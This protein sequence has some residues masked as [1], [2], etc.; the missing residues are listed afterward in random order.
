MAENGMEMEIIAYRDCKHC[1]IRFENG[2]IVKNK[3]YHNFLIGHVG[4]PTDN[5]IGQKSNNKNGMEMTII[6]YRSAKD[7]DVRFEN[8]IIVKHR[9]YNNFIKGTIELPKILR[10]HEKHIANNGMEME[11]IAYRSAT[12]MDIRFENGKIQRHVSYANFKRGVVGRQDEPISSRIG[13]IRNANNGLEMRLLKV[14]SPSNVTIQF[15]DGIIVQ[16]KL[17][18]AF[19]AGAIAH[20]HIGSGSDNCFYG[21]ITK[22]AFSNDKDTYYDCTFS[23]GEKDLLTPQE[24]MKRQGVKFAF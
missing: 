2:V 12:D 21:V 16:N 13:R 19:R 5:R 3:T 7:I 4:L 1:D 8:G 9:C 6:K 14:I 18:T 11:I 15:C 20:P 22:K 23:D 17:Y 10:L 24:I